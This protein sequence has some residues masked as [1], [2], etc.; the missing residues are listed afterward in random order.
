MR[1]KTE[2]YG[3]GERA[4]LEDLIAAH[5]NADAVRLRIVQHSQLADAALLPLVAGQA[6]QPRSLI[7]QHHLQATTSSWTDYSI[8]RPR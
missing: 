7:E 1:A 3:R 2:K 4:D 8:R 5:E 6:E